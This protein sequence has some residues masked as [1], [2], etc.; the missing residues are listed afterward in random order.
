M[1]SKTIAAMTLAV[2]LGTT[3]AAVAQG[4][5]G[6]NGFY[7]NRFNLGY[8]SSARHDPTNTNGH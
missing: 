6:D 8:S 7:P 3:A 4:W 5:Q 2:F 1:F